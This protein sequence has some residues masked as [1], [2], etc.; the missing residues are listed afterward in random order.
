MQTVRF[1]A[2]LLLILTLACRLT[3]TPAVPEV[4]ETPAPTGQPTQPPI[5]ARPPAPLGGPL[6]PNPPVTPLRLAFSH[7]STGEDW[8]KP[9]FIPLLNIFVHCWQG[10]G[11]CPHWTPSLG[12]WSVTPASGAARSQTWRE[13]PQFF[14]LESPH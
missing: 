8:L 9:Q 5:A 11:G 13:Q 2:I 14:C 10:D 12:G 7:H 1:S 6:N 4:G 3:P